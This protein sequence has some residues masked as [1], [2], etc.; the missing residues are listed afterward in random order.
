MYRRSLCAGLVL[1]LLPAC[2]TPPRLSSL[3][4]GLAVAFVVVK[5]EGSGGE[6]SVS[7]KALGS[8]MA[9]GAGSGAVIGGLWGLVCGP[10]AVLCIPLAATA[11]AGAGTAVG[12]AVGL[13]GA[14]S[15]D[16]A[17]QLRGRMARAQRAHDPLDELR[18]HVAEKARR[19][20]KLD[21]DPPAFVVTIQ[22]QDIQLT[23]TRDEQVGF[24]LEA[25]VSVR[26]A[27]QPPASTLEKAYRYAGPVSPLA[28][29][30]DND[31]DFVESS[32]SNAHN[33]I[34]SQIVAELAAK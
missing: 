4:S 27:G 21:I 29:W 13:T 5:A 16:K 31:S 1:S 30:L 11:G 17:A 32:L 6:L 33:Q 28:V 14:L 24:W 9:A 10:W 26:P 20:W 7:N 8:G 2:A 23:S 25:L 22:L 12:A 19:Y 34:A 18:R 15:K 3:R